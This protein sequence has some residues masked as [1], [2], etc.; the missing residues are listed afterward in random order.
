MYFGHFRSFESI[1]V[2]FI[3]FK[4]IFG[5][6]RGF[7]GIFFAHFRGVGCILVSLEVSMLF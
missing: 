1:L 3:G 6:F 5:N 4:G 2:I 7:K